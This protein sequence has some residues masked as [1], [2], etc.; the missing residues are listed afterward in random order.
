MKQPAK[1]SENDSKYKNFQKMRSR[2]SAHDDDDES[3]KMN[4]QNRSNNYLTFFMEKLTNQQKNLRNLEKED[5]FALDKK[6]TQDV[7]EDPSI[8]KVAKESRISKAFSESIIQKI[9][10]LVLF[11]NICFTMINLEFFVSDI[12]E[13]Q[14]NFLVQV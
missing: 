12:D 10:V 3:Q 7:S 1:S 14:Y 8:Q 4:F 11:L 2:R 9:M 6:D 5:I 13:L